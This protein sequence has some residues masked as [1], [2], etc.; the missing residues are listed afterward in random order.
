M[1]TFVTYHDVLGCDYGGQA[2]P[3][4]RVYA[5]LLREPLYGGGVQPAA[6]QPQLPLTLSH[7]TSKPG[8]ELALSCQRTF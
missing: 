4:H 7:R 3:H 8:Q 2:L 1:A 6:R 5:G